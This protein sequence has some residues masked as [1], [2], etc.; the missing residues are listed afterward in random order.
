MKF[1]F[2]IQPYQTDAVENTVAVFSGQ[3][4]FDNEF[5]RRDLGKREKDKYELEGEDTGFRNHEI[6]IS[7]EQLLANI[8]TIKPAVKLYLQKILYPIWAK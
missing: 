3:P 6:E 7:S 2:K 4:F 8:R 1:K 5:Y